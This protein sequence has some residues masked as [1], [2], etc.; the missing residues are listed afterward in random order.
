MRISGSMVPVRRFIAAAL[1][2]G[3]LLAVPRG[4][5][6]LSPLT[7]AERQP[8]I[9]AFVA[10]QQNTHTYQA[11]LHQTLQLS[12]MKKPIESEAHVYYKAPDS[13]RLS[14]TSPAGEYLIITGDDVYLKKNNRP[15]VHR[16]NTAQKGRPA[17]DARMLLSL[18][19]GGA[20]DWGALFAFEMA[21]DGD[22]LVVTLHPRGDDP[23]A[24]NVTIENTITLP[25]YGLQSIRINFGQDNAMTYDFTNALRNAPIDD[26]T[27]VPPDSDRKL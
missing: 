8:Y 10:K 20:K 26:T 24:R 7:D 15:L 19:Q 17:E 5:P 21:R 3:I 18:F 13:M 1:A 2:S 11:E 12:G 23:R 22:R 16:K 6:A 14:F 27:F 4:V 9:D 25:A